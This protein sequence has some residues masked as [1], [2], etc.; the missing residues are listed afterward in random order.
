MQQFLE[1]ILNN[2]ITEKM[3]IDRPT[4]NMIHR[5]EVHWSTKNSLKNWL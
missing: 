4:D 1:F 5:V 2:R 3:F